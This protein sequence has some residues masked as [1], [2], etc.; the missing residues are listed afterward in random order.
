MYQ[1]ADYL[2]DSQ[3]TNV[4]DFAANT[5]PWL[6]RKV[7]KAPLGQED[8]VSAIEMLSGWEDTGAHSQPIQYGYMRITGEDAQHLAARGGGFVEIGFVTSTLYP[9]SAVLYM[10]REEPVTEADAAERLP[11]EGQMIPREVE[12]GWRDVEEGRIRDG[13][14]R[15]DRKMEPPPPSKPRPGRHVG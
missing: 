2:P 7:W 1:Y 14:L 8:H 5:R 6:D 12:E 3:P 4:P 10:D 9:W 15:T 11:Q 13:E